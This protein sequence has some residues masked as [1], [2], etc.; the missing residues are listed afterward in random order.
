VLVLQISLLNHT[1]EAISAKIQKLLG[2][3]Q[4]AA[5]AAMAGEKM[6]SCCGPA[7]TAWLLADFARDPPEVETDSDVSSD[8]T[9]RVRT[10]GKKGRDKEKEKE[11]STVWWPKF[12]KHRSKGLS[13]SAVSSAAHSAVHSAANSD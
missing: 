11:L 12:D 6:R 13:R 8:D 1:P 4:Y 3:P 5:A 7:L 2:Q 9:E 10:G